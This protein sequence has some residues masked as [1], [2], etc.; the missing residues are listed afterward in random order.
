MD[1][2]DR[3]RLKKRLFSVIKGRAKKRSKEFKLAPDE[4]FELCC[5]PCFY[6]GSIGSSELNY[7]GL[8]LNYNGLDR[9]NSA[10]GYI[11]E[12]VVP[13]CT[14]CNSLKG[15]MV[16]EHWFDFLNSVLANFHPIDSQEPPP[17]PFKVP[18]QP[19]RKSKRYFRGR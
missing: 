18:P 6:C 3:E 7:Q 11:S 13:C 1:F 2:K 4:V 9:V 14:F 15:A 10:Q 5:S 19:E 12:N 17:I 16:P 8:S